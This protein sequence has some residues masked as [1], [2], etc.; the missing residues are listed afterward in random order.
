MIRG[1]SGGWGTCFRTV[2]SRG[3]PY[4]IACW[5]DTIAVDLDSS[6]IITL[7]AVTGS[8]IGV[9]SGHTARVASTTF[10]PDGTSLVSGSKDTTIK[11]W[12]MQTGGVVKTFQGHTGPVTSVSISPDCTT[13]ASGSEDKTI[14]LW[15]IQT[16]V[17]LYYAASV[18]CELYSLLP[19]GPSMSHVHIW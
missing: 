7:N 10:S 19:F 8:K 5:E 16:G 12:D 6:S 4:A 15:N 13:I 1:L 9:L 2:L 18:L 14:H 17:P 3:S 11:L